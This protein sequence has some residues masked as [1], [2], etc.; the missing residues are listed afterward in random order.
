[1]L[2]RLLA[3]ARTGRVRAIL[4]WALDRL[5]RSMLG[6]IQTVLECDR[7]A[8]PVI[9]SWPLRLPQGSC[10]PGAVEVRN[11]D[12]VGDAAQDRFDAP[13]IL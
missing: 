12:R 7:I 9:S 11:H 1:V 4:I 2:D 13:R 3:D 6:A 10:R 5:H 8:A